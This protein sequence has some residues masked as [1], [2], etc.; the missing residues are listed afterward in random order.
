MNYYAAQ[1]KITRR[2]TSMD[3]IK[4]NTIVEIDGTR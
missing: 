1:R 3:K 2:I 4:M